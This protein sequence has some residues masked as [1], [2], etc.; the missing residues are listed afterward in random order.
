MVLEIAQVWKLEAYIRFI[1]VLQ[2]FRCECWRHVLWL[3]QSRAGVAQ[4][5]KQ[6]PSWSLAGIGT[7]VVSCVVRGGT[8]RPDVTAMNTNRTNGML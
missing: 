2:W 8:G 1:L 6:Q 4:A 3:G 5:E 7:H